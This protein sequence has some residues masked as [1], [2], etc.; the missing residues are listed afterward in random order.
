MWLTA[1]VATLTTLVSW[2]GRGRAGRTGG[3]SAGRGRG[4]RGGRGMARPG[5]GGKRRQRHAQLA[6]SSHL[7]AAPWAAGRCAL[8]QPLTMACLPSTMAS[9]ARSMRGR[10]SLKKARPSRADSCRGREPG[11][12]RPRSGGAGLGGCSCRR[13]CPIPL[14]AHERAPQPDTPRP[15]RGTPPPPAPQMRF[16]SSQARTLGDGLAVGSTLILSHSFRKAGS[17]L[18]MLPAE[19]A[20][21]GQAG[22]NVG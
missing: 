19:A 7:C 5:C 1:A 14:S 21:A 12:I 3:G 18:Q 20:P 9:L 10:P 2:A 6:A 8:S 15:R 4:E 17:G 13:T 11:R 22:E 16:P